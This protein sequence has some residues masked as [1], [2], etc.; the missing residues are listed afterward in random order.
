MT[1]AALPGDLACWLTAAYPRS[2]RGAGPDVA[3][4]AA[5][6]EV[7]PSTVR[8][9]LTD[10]RARLTRLNVGQVRTVRRRAV[11][12]GRG[13]YRWPAPPAGALDRE[14]QAVREARDAAELVDRRPATAEKLW[15]DRHWLEVHQVLVVHIARA[16]VYQV[17]ATRGTVTTS[18]HEYLTRHTELVAHLEVPHRFAGTLL[19]HAV[20]EHAGTDRCVPPTD[21]VRGGR[22]Y[23]WTDR[24]G[25]L[26]VDNLA[27]LVGSN[28]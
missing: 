28:A 7:A 4:A 23:C 9:W 2:R 17:F 11:L 18:H 14:A 20:L 5:T 27:E 25:G 1:T 22:S 21:L 16:A 26:D 13:H 15:R 10:P 24:A 6:L 3:L 19:T 8:R 12:R